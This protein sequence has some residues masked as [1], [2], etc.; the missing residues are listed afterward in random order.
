MLQMARAGGFAH[1]V[2][3][4][5]LP[6]FA[7]FRGSATIQTLSVQTIV[8]ATVRYNQLFTITAEIIGREPTQADED[9]LGETA[10]ALLFLGEQAASQATQEPLP[11]ATLPP[12]PEGTPAPA[13]VKVQRDETPLTLDYAPSVTHLDSFTLSGQ[14]E[15]NTPMRYYINGIGY[16]RFSADADG[17]YTIEIRSLPKT[18]KNLIAIYAIG[19]KGYGV[20]GFSISFEQMKVPMAVT[21]LTQGIEG[22][23]ALITGTALKG[24]AV[25]VLYR[26]KAYD[27]QMAEDGSF[28]CLVDLPKLGENLFT[29]RATQEG[30]LRCDEKLTVIRLPSDVDKQESFIKSVKNIAYEKLIA[31]PESYANAPVQYVGQILFLSGQNGQ[32]LAVIDTK[33]GQSPVAILCQDINGMELNQEVNVLCTLTGALR[34]VSLPSGLSLIPEARLNW[35]LSSK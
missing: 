14:T 21:R 26:N 6:E 3:S 33:N 34:E 12:A 35:L 5:K 19:D 31:K 13:Q 16:D 7:V 17:R 20:V 4:D 2:W 15:P 8:Y 24:S 29:V 23:Q 18:G 30:Y 22:A 1:G 10:S 11:Q 28:T 25:Q 27:A 9:A 32:P